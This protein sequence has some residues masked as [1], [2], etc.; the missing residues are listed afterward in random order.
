MFLVLALVVEVR[1][2]LLIGEVMVE[3]FWLWLEYS[4]YTDSYV[5]YC[6]I[7][8][9]LHVFYNIIY[10]CI[11]IFRFFFWTHIL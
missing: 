6:F 3:C 7:Q 5:S 9:C 1:Q 4:R 10:L 2:K 11:F 8:F